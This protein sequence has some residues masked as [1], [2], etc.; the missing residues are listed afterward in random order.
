MCV[1][2]LEDRD[3]LVAHKVELIAYTL[4]T[5]SLLLPAA[6]GATAIGATADL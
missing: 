3:D 4:Y 5:S 2:D 6:T 1:C